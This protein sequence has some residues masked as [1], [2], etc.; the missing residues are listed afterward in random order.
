MYQLDE[1][2]QKIGE[3]CSG[4]DYIRKATDECNG[5]LSTLTRDTIIQGE[6]IKAA[7]KRLDTITPIVDNLNNMKNKSVG[8]IITF[9]VL[10]GGTG[11]LLTKLIDKLF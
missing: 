6:Q 1:M 11:S 7:H 9:G 3:M 4:I 5:K 8:A 10:S 2:S